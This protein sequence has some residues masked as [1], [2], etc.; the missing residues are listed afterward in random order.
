LTEVNLSVNP[1]LGFKVGNKHVLIKLYFKEEKLTSSEAKI[2]LVSMDLAFSKHPEAL[3]YEF[4]ILD[5]RRNKLYTSNASD[6]FLKTLFLI[7]T[8]NFIKIY[9]AI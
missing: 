4:K 3:E 2:L 1:E 8:D 7:E 6:D 9:K 5:V